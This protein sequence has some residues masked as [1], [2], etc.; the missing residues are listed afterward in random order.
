MALTA[1]DIATIEALGA[2][3]SGSCG[4]R[5][6]SRNAHGPFNRDRVTPNNPQTGKQQFYRG[7]FGAL[8]A[9]WLGTLTPAQRD[10]WDAYATRRR[11]SFRGPRI[12]L[13]GFNEFMRINWPRF[14]ASVAVT[15]DPPSLMAGLDAA[16]FRCSWTSPSTFLQV[17]FDV[18]QPWQFIVGTWVIVHATDQRPSS[19]N[20]F[21]PPYE[22]RGKF[23]ATA[24]PPRP[25]QMLAA[26]VRGSRCFYKITIACGDGRLAHWDA[27]RLIVG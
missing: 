24:I 27:D 14:R 17:D 19:I 5:T 11:Q 18:G 8:S 2:G 25:I 13:S 21:K 16:K 15:S 10:A 12:Q 9:S 26:G 23:L 20:S 1:Q 22:F 7:R 3:L 4:D 6:W